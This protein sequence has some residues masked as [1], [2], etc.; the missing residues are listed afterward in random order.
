MRQ[1]LSGRKFGLGGGWGCGGGGGGDNRGYEGWMWPECFIQHLKLSQDELIRKTVHGNHM[2]QL[3]LSQGI[4]PKI[5]N[6]ECQKFHEYLK[7]K[8]CTSVLVCFLLL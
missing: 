4:K 2:K 7:I 5:K 6:K 8:Q 1:G 3:F